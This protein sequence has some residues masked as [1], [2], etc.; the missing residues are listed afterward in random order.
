MRSSE[1]LVLALGGLPV[2][3]RVPALL[4]ACGCEDLRRG[5]AQCGY[6]SVAYASE[7][8]IRDPNTSGLMTY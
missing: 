3:H 2:C 7:T 8:G 5:T 4:F 6:G 1:T